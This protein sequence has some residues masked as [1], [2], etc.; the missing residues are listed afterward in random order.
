M[1]D[2]RVGGSHEDY[3]GTGYPDGL[4]GDAIPIESRIRSACD[5]FG[6]MTTDRTYRKALPME[7]AVAEL[8]RCAGTQF[9][10]RVVATLVEVLDEAP[11]RPTAVESG[12]PT[13]AG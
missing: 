6:A 10:P 1:G 9:D 13:A 11:T 2:R 7:A 3:D 8:R 5:A 4:A 12:M